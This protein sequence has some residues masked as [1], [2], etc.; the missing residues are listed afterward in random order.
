MKSIPYGRGYSFD[1]CNDDQDCRGN[2]VCTLGDFS[3]LCNNYPT[4]SYNCFC[5]KKATQLC[6]SCRQYE[7]FPFEVCARIV[8]TNDRKGVCASRVT[9]GEGI[10]EGIGREANRS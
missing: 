3:G 9:L 10:F 8:S 1:K 5:F 6:S 2:R 7:A 4:A